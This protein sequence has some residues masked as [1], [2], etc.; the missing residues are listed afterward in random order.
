MTIP[1][2]NAAVVRS[3]GIGF[4]V[5]LSV[6]CGSGSEVVSAP[7]IDASTGTSPDVSAERASLIYAMDPVYGA[8]FS[9]VWLGEALPGVA[10]WIGAALIATA[11]AS[12]ALLEWDKTQLTQKQEEESST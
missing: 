4:V 11:A 9:Y 5:L 8:A 1:V 3:L 2:S 6:G 7:P 12:Q 10:G